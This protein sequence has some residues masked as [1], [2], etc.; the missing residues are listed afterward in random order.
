MK[1]YILLFSALVLIFSSCSSSRYGHV[2]KG[3]KHTAKV[4]KHK[5]KY[6]KKQSNEITTLDLKKADLNATLA[7]IEVELEKVDFE[8]V[9]KT[10]TKAAEKRN[11][12][13]AVKKDNVKKDNAFVLSPPAIKKTLKQNSE[14]AL[15]EVQASR[16]WLYYIVVGLIFLLL[17]AIIVWPFGWIFY[18]VGVIAI[19]VG[20]LALIGIV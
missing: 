4:V 6:S 14:K 16:S 7:A 18:L 19:I 1:N 10:E 17:A 15:E 2:P 13:S 11:T 9:E 8:A 20:L 5:S 3:S 12:N